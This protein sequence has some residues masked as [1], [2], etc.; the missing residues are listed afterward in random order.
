MAVAEP[1]GYSRMVGFSSCESVTGTP[2]IAS[3]SIAPMAFSWTG[4]ATDHSRHTAT[5]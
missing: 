4:F 1:R 2:G 3:A 5:A